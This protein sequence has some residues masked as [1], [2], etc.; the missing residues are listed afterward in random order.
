MTFVSARPGQAASVTSCTQAGNVSS[1]TEAGFVTF[2]TQAWYEIHPSIFNLDMYLTYSTQI[3]LSHTGRSYHYQ[4]S[5][6][7]PTHFSFHLS[8]HLHCH[9]VSMIALLI[10]LNYSKSHSGTQEDKD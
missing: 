5:F 7:S 3:M 6:S 2:H 4:C 9:V 10:D 8:T 1:Y